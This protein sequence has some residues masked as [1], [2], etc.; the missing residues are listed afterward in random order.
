MA[1]LPTPPATLSAAILFVNA[2]SRVP[3]GEYSTMAMLPSILSAR[4]NIARQGRRSA[5]AGKHSRVVPITT[6][7]VPNVVSRLPLRL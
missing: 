2:V 3:L 6:P 1:I 4:E 5:K 7:L